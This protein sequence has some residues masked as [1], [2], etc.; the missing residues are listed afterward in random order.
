MNDINALSII[1]GNDINTV[2]E[3]LRK[4]ASFQAVVQKT[5]KVD[6]DFGTV[7]GISKP[8]LFKAGAEKINM[9]MQ[10]SPEY[11]FLE[12]TI[13]FKE[14]FFNYEIKC[15][16]VRNLIQDGVL[17]KLPVAQ[18]VGSCNSKE[19]K[20]RYTN[21][22]E[23]DVPPEL[24]KATLKSYKNKWGQLTYTI[25]NPDPY[26]IANTILKMA[27]KRAYVDATLQIAALS[28][29][30][31]QDEEIVEA[32]GTEFTDNIDDT[33]TGIVSN[34]MDIGNFVIT[35]G[36]KHKGKNLNKIFA[37]GDTNYIQYLVDK[38]NDPETRTVC[39]KFLTSKGKTTDPTLLKPTPNPT[40]I[41][42]AK[43]VFSDADEQELPFVL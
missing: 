3:T 29:V 33:T 30:F 34:S 16:L 41:A 35:F 32:L 19:K 10:V 17:I 14:G 42:K 27:K 21:V 12:R 1:E 11:D 43:E 36:T 40:P 26:T 25:P 20:Y 38:T 39:A 4:I 7:K 22:K 15:T 28:E 18:G 8:F 2:S 9:L 5:L 23:S 13:D 24:D 31:T 37:E 6:K